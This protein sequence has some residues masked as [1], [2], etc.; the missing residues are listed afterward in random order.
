MASLA[1]APNGSNETVNKTTTTKGTSVVIE[2]KLRDDELNES[3]KGIDHVLTTYKG[4][5]NVLT[6]PLINVLESMKKQ[7][8]ERV[9]YQ[10]TLP[11]QQQQPPPPPPVDEFMLTCQELSEKKVDI[12]RLYT[13]L[14]FEQIIKS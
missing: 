13:V 11:K 2:M 14:K 7:L 12:E 8:K 10:S 9:K 1:V 3:I 6:K 5:E 4:R